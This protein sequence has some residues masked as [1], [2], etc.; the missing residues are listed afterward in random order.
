VKLFRPRS[1][2][3]YGVLVLMLAAWWLKIEPGSSSRARRSTSAPAPS[4]EWVSLTG[5][6]LV[7]E[8]GN[9]GDSFLIRHESGEHIFRLYFV[10]CAEKNRHRFNED[11]LLDQAAYFGG[12]T[13]KETIALGQEART[14][15]LSLLEQCPF[16]IF[17]RWEPVFD[18]RRHYA[19]LRI[20]LP[21]GTQHWLS[22]L[23]VDRGLARIHTKG[24]AWP[25]GT[26]ESVI[27]KELRHLENQ[28]RFQARGG[29]RRAAAASSPGR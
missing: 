17:T 15:V 3:W 27:K 6:Q 11:R 16:E 10:D 26:N 8:S 5:E 13:E 12:L 9:D 20:T 29:W 25:D 14:Y 2:P 28:A 24:A 1:L 19:H 4:R 7:A 21:D 18:D 23:L 22:H